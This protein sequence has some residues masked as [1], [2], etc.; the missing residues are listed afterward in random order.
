[1]PRQLTLSVGLPDH[2]SFANY[3][4]GSN[5]EAVE[6][7]KAI[8]HKCS[9]LLFVSGEPGSGKSHLLYAAQKMSIAAG[10]P[11]TYLSM[12][13][14][15]VR[16]SLGGFEN[17]GILVCVDDIEQVA[18]KRQL[19]RLLFNLIEQNR[20]VDGALIIACERRPA[21]YSFLMADLVSR[22]QSG[23]SY[24]LQP[25]TD[26]HKSAAMRLRARQRGFDLPD[27]VI[28]YVMKR[29]PRDTAALFVLLDRI[30]KA[31]LSEQRRV[32]IPLVKNL[33]E[34]QR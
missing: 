1:M 3:Y 7:I 33:E 25:L 5:T 16:L 9:G 19:E 14:E 15:R 2:A 30:D 32:T 4:T 11:A 13:D 18:G 21:E 26:S 6:A 27:E 17:L 29:F 22:L 31:S 20:Q 28:S 34:K 23:V 10:Q 8:A 12:S 24:R